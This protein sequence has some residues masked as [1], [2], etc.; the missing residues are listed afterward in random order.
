MPSSPFEQMQSLQSAGIEILGGLAD[1]GFASAQ[2]LIELNLRA[3]KSSLGDAQEATRKA[4]AARDVAELLALHNGLFQSAIE[5]A[6]AY[7]RELFEIAVA[8]QGD[9]AKVADA[10]FEESKRRMQEVIDSAGKNSPAGSEVA[11]AAWQSAL[12]AGASM[13]ESMQQAA[14]QAMEAA[15]SNLNVATA[16]ASQP[17]QAPAA[18]ARA[19]RH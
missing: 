7:Q 12:T 9:F 18:P 1:K 2:K 11:L 6:L 15:E 10:Q 4:L 17:Q 19:T 14:R 3:M 13:C 5:K 16:A 8:T